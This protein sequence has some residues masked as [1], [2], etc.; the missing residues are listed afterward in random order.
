MLMLSNETQPCESRVDFLF[1]GMVFKVR[2]GGKN[3]GNFPTG[4][5]SVREHDHTGAERTGSQLKK[6]PFSAPG[7]A[8]PKTGTTVRLQKSQTG[9]K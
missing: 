5:K 4:T 9:K 1:A 7:P 8:L 2:E 3:R 6:I